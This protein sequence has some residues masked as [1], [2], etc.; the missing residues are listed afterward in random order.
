MY[1]E[2]TGAYRTDSLFKERI[3]KRHKNKGLKAVY[4]LTE[5]DAVGDCKKLYDI[6][7][8]SVDEYD[9]AIKAF[10][11]KGHLDKLKQVGWFMAGWQ[12]CVSFRGYNAWLEDMEHR[13]QSLGKRIL[14]EKA[15]DG[16]VSAAKKLVDMYKTTAS[17]GRPK[18]EDITRE[19]KKQAEE[20]TDI[21]DDLKRLNV[22]KL[23]G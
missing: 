4:A 2:Q 18:K 22:I 9:F 6:F 13:D 1:L 12:G 11:S 3:A 21:E 14:M 20:K 5:R 16:D 23:R 7:I 15:E 17:K 19:A 10:G 8:N